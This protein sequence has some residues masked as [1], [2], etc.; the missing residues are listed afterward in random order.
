MGAALKSTPRVEGTKPL[1]R[2]LAGE[3]LE[4]PPV[5]LMRQAGRYLPEYRAIREETRDFLELCLSPELATEVTLQPVRRFPLDAAILFSDILVLPYALGQ[6]VAFREGEGPVLEPV[7][8]AADVAKLRL[9]HVD[10]RLAP[11]CETVRSVRA[12]LPDETALIGFAGAPWT[13]ATYM[14]EGGTSRDFGSVKGWAFRQPDEF[15]RLI[16]L[17]VKA[18]ANFLVRQAEAGAEALQIFDTWAGA[19]PE[20]GVR[21]WVMDP[22]RSIVERIKAAHP[23]VPVIGFPRG[24][25]VLYADYAP[26]TGV[27]AV[28]LDSSVP[29]GWAA[30][31]LQPLC[32][33][34]G[35]LDPHVLA[36]GG[37]AL[38]AEAERIL[39]A[40]GHGPFVFNLGHGVLP[41]TPPDHVAELVRMVRSWR[42]R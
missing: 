6:D 5:W 13:V 26:E 18:T 40:L 36:A 10:E 30:E 1:L 27:D 15:E 38:R 37:V 11:V 24:I 41:E 21:R 33:V 14:V 31:T 32:P 12:R 16:E 39:D 35:N 19:L 28:S 34:Q 4:R 2:A 9:D 23:K 17:L 20:S 25:G 7:R 8:S 42:K 22:V 3:R 29:V